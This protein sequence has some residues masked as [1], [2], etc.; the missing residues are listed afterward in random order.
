[1]KR[2]TKIDWTD[3]I[4]YSK[5]L[6]LEEKYK[7]MLKLYSDAGEEIKKLKEA[8]EMLKKQVETDMKEL[9]RRRAENKRLGEEAK[10]WKQKYDNLKYQVKI[11]DLC[12]ENL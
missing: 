1:M 3:F 7:G 9:E 11:S 10:K 6:D 8:N 12:D 4:P 2:I 5:Y